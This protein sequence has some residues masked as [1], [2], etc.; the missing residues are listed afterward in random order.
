MTD[1][2]SAPRR[3]ALLLFDRFELLDVFGPAEMFGLVPSAFQIELIGPQPGPVASAQGPEVVA[4]RSFSAVDDLDL[5]L[6]PG[7]VGTRAEVANEALLAWLRRIS[8]QAQYVTSVCTGAALLARAGLLDGR[9]ATT[10]KWAFEWVAAQGPQVE[11]VKK[12][13]W[14]EDGAFW[15][16]SGVSAGMDMAL[17]LIERMAGADVAAKVANGAE[18]ARHVDADWDPFA[19]L[20]DFTKS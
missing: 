14:V 17:A 11:W 12:A 5:L 7:G 19:E 1:E 4:A 2:T 10:N 18:Y 13:R 16:S 8:E 6:V 9:R 20:Y 15:T 3:V